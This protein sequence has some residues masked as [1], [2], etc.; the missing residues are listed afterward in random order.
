VS[1]LGGARERY[2]LGRLFAAARVAD[3]TALR[4]LFWSVGAP[5]LPLLLLGRMAAKAFGT[6]P[7]LAPFVRALP[8]LILFTLTWSGGEW[9][10]YVSRRGPR[11]L[12]IER[13][14]S[15]LTS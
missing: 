8:A 1:P 10:G 2:E 12:T 7:L 15:N 14:H 3:A 6:P 13:E 4:R 5:L 9:V 11:V